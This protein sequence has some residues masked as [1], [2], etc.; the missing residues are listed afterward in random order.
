MVQG[1][2][3]ESNQLDCRHYDCLEAGKATHFGLTYGFINGHFVD[4]N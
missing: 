4:S 2:S 1:N 3:H